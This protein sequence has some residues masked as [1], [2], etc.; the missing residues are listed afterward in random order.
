MWGPR[1]YLFLSEADIS[2]KSDI[3]NALS[4]K[5]PYTYKGYSVNFTEP[6][7]NDCGVQHP[8]FITE[9]N[10]NPL[11]FI[12]TFDEYLNEQLGTADLDNIHPFNGSHFQNTD[13][14]RWYQASSL[15]IT[16]IVQRKSKK[17]SAI[18]MRLNYI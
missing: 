11:V 10:V 13:Y 2:K 4:E 14:Y 6:D 9:G 7:P 8:K 1:F 12:H 17:S 18:P 5:L 3:I 15:L 16:L